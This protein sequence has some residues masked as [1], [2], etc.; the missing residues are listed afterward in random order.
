MYTDDLMCAT[1]EQVLKEIFGTDDIVIMPSALA[2][3]VSPI[4]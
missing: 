3:W 2:V 1:C 4:N